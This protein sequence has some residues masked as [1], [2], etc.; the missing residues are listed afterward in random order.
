MMVEFFVLFLAVAI[1][2]LAAVAVFATGGED[3]L[4]GKTDTDS[5]KYD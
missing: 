2:P 5:R 3:G 4:G 1:A